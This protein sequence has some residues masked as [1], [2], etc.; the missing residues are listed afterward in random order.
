MSFMD[1]LKRSLGY[2]EEETNHQDDKRKRSDHINYEIQYSVYYYVF[3]QASLL[4]D[5]QY[6]TENKPQQR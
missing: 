3:V 5:N 4:S 1:N 2:E 6:Y